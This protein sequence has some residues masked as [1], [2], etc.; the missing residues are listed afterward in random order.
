MV[1]RFGFL[2]QQQ[3]WATGLVDMRARTYRPTWGRFLTLDPTGLAAGPNLYAFAGSSPQTFVDPLGLHSEYGWGDIAAALG[4]SGVATAWND[5]GA[6]ATAA[7]APPPT[8]ELQ[9]AGRFTKGV[10]EGAIV[11]PIL[12]VAAL[13]VKCSSPDPTQCLEAIGEMYVSSFKAQGAF[14]HAYGTG[15]S[16]SMKQQVCGLGRGDCVE[17]AGVAFGMGLTMLEPLVGEMAAAGALGAGARSAA[18]EGVAAAADAAPSNALF[19]RAGAGGGWRVINET[20]GG[21]I[22]QSHPLSCGSACGEMVSGIAQDQ[23]I[24]R[25]G[26]PTSAVAL[27][28]EMGDGWLGGELSS[29]MRSLLENNISWIAQLKEFG[30]IA[31]MVV[32]DGLDEAGNVM[33]RDPWDGGSTYQMT[34]P[35]FE[36]AWTGYAVVPK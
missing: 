13:G 33:I 20:P 19:P 10:V 34:V 9:V 25:A 15:D 22:A 14:Y 8:P 26:A 5:P 12:S 3:D 32:V 18:G 28:E 17:G 11:N 7:I 21:A 36:S 27:A 30:S 16:A 31:H 35:D 1:N 2:G 23:L 24:A 29:G 4:G 6:A